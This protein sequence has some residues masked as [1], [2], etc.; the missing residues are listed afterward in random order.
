MPKASV[1][2][3]R[4]LVD[5]EGFDEDIVDIM[6]GAGMTDAVVKFET[7]NLQ[8]KAQLY[9]ALTLNYPSKEDVPKEGLMLF[10]DELTLSNETI[11]KLIKT[12]KVTINGSFWKLSIIDRSFKLKESKPAIDLKEKAE[13]EN[14]KV[15]TEIAIKNISKLVANNELDYIFD[16]VTYIDKDLAIMGSNVIF[17]EKY[18]FEINKPDTNGVTISKKE[19]G[20]KTSTVFDIVLHRSIKD[21]GEYILF[22]GKKVHLFRMSTLASN[23]SE[24][25]LP[26]TVTSRCLFAIKNTKE[27]K[28]LICAK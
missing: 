17:I 8:D 5:I 25:A 11:A 16:T 23:P 1:V 9:R 13:R 10:V 3:K 20:K 2:E 21:F 26:K 18:F 4:Y 27:N 22:T 24:E 15:Q 28:E 6:Y 19:D 12:G 14:S 7:N